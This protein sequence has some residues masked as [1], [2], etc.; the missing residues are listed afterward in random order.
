MIKSLFWLNQYNIKQSYYSNLIFNSIINNTKHKFS[1]GLNFTYDKYGEFVNVND[2]SR[3]DNSV[4]AFEYTYDNT[5]NFS[6]VLGGRIDNPIVWG[7]YAKIA[8]A[9][10]SLGERSFAIFSR[11]RKRS[12]NVFLPKINT[13]VGSRTFVF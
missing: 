10:Q 8:C 9:I 7:L 4:G 11:K 5:D 3:I 1:T 6:V 2:Y 12:A 13:F